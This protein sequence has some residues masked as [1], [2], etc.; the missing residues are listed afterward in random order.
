MTPA[1]IDL[2]ASRR[3]RL[4]ALAAGAT[5]LLAA[6]VGARLD[7]RLD[8]MKIQPRRLLAA[9]CGIGTDLARLRNRYPG[10]EILALDE[11]KPELQLVRAQSGKGGWLDTLRAALG[12]GARAPLAIAAALARLPMAPASVG[13][14]WSNLALQRTTDPLPAIR[15]MH[16][17]LEAGGLFIFSTL[18]PDTLKELRQAF[19]AADRG[20]PHVHD[21]IDM[22][23][24]GD[25]L[26][27]CGF[28]A[29]VMEM[30]TLTL[31]YDHVKALARDLRAMGATNSLVA[32]RRGLSGRSMWERLSAA[33][34]SA[35]AHDRLAASFEVV[36]GHAWKPQPRP[37]A[38][39]TPQ[40]VKFY[41]GWERK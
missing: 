37:S 7:E 22:H 18:G 36:Y 17:V 40:V 15:E 12:L 6:E 11:L 27:E 9:G 29:P 16:R 23:D 14:V 4:R 30:E 13:L 19:A 20:F 39:D 26:V 2:R 41:P 5:P 8:L 28:T 38:A 21:F 24:L 33:L 1:Q 3:A 32:R 10:S 34:E 31:T 25:M 35:R